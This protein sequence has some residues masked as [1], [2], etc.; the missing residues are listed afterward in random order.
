ME[1]EVK[2][3]YEII[4]NPFSLKIITSEQSEQ[5]ENIILYEL[6][7]SKIGCGS[8]SV[9]QKF[10]VDVLSYHKLIVD[11]LY[12]SR[13]KVIMYLKHLI[14]DKEPLLIYANSHAIANFNTDHE[15]VLKCIKPEKLKIIGPCNYY[16]YKLG[17]KQI[18]LF[19]E[20]H[21]PFDN[22]K[23]YNSM[24]ISGYINYLD[25][26]GNT[27]TVLIE[28]DRLYYE[29]EC[30]YISM[31][32]HNSIDSYGLYELELMKFK[33]MKP[34]YVDQ[35]K[36]FSE[37]TEILAGIIAKFLQIIHNAKDQSTLMTP[38]N[39]LETIFGIL[40]K[41]EYSGTMGLLLKEKLD[42]RYLEILKLHN[43]DIN[44]VK[45]MTTNIINLIEAHTMP[46]FTKTYDIKDFKIPYGFTSLMDVIVINR[47]LASDTNDIIVYSGKG[48]TR[49]YMMILSVMK[50]KL[51][52]Y[53]ISK[54]NSIEITL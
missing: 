43:T 28:S 16:K 52:E 8:N 44:I 36:K 53:H 9:S 37:Q 14:Y 32:D 33:N 31:M 49:I 26:N 38:H 39:C 2:F 46:N 19:G 22:P 25:I 4:L 50:A 10:R 3:Y 1:I 41:G 47:L 15:N 11:K 27:S 30:E 34:E 6:S 7:P 12:I 35:R 24:T 21:L 5:S 48:H 18:T 40:F 42:S 17:E 20:Y 45:I 51:L 54:E 29:I 23:D 13:F